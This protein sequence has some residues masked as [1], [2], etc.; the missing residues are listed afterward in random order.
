MKAPERLS[1]IVA[2]LLGAGAFAASESHNVEELAASGRTR[3]ERACA[4]CH[5]AVKGPSGP[6]D[7]GEL[8]RSRDLAWLKRWNREGAAGLAG[9]IEKARAK[10][11]PRPGSPRPTPV[12]PS[13]NDEAIEEIYLY[14]KTAPR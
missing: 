4:S 10:A 2:F 14:L 12:L 8:A 9:H 11:S 3:F 13:L 6:A 5:N 1:V 7:L